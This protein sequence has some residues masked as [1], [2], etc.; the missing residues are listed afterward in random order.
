MDEEDVRMTGR[1]DKV[2][3]RMNAVVSESRISF[4][5]TFLGENIVVLSLQVAN[6]LGESMIQ[7]QYGYTDKGMRN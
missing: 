4:N 6:N 2:E 5:P 3:K 7:D 1:S